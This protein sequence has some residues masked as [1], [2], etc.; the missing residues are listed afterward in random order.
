MATAPEQ[1]APAA[2]APTSQTPEQRLANYFSTQDEQPAPAE[3]EADSG[4]YEVEQEPAG[5]DAGEEQEQAAQ[6]ED[7]PEYEITHDGKPKRLKLS[8]LR[9]YA[10][11]GFDYTTKTQSVASERQAVSELRQ[12]LTQQQQMMGALSQQIMERQLAEKEYRSLAGA[13]FA[14]LAES[15]PLEAV[16][17]QAKLL[18]ARGRLEEADGRLREAAGQWQQQQQ[19]AQRA[20][21]QAE[22]A[23]VIESVPEWR[24]EGKR[25]T[26]AKKIRDYLQG[27]GYQAAEID[28]LADSRALILAR[29]AWLYDSLQKTKPEVARRAAEA[30]AKQPRT[31][32]LTTAAEIEQKKLR[33]RLKQSGSVEDAAALFLKLQR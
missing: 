29:K 20:A 31:A 21:L 3:A 23:R 17:H 15:D 11:K 28:G 18:Q 8:E 6:A 7:D 33:S 5:E 22:Y 2:L 14:A 1:A 16:K 4:E 19:T 10:Q 32:G 25:A 27:A 9:E 30:P 13:D 26:E 12:A 24:D